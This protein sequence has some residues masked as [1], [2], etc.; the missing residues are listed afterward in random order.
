[1]QLPLLSSYKDSGN[2]GNYFSDI[3]SG[4]DGKKGSGQYETVRAMERLHTSRVGRKPL[5]FQ[6]PL[7]VSEI[8]LPEKVRF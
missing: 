5:S 7:A 2:I 4:V 6:K 8:P 1:M 3:S